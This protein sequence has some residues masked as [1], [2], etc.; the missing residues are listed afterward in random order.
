MKKRKMCECVKTDFFT[1]L[2]MSKDFNNLIF[3]YIFV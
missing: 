3:F 1:V 2:M